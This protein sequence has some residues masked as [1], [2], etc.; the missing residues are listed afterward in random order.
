[1]FLFLFLSFWLS[2]IFFINYQI[3]FD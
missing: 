2:C 3:L 1:L